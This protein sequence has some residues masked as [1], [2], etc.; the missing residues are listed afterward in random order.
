MKRSTNNSEVKKLNRN[1]VFRYIN[2]CEET[3]M[4]EISA[5][6]DI[7]SPTVLTIVKELKEDGLIT[8]VGEFKSTGGRKA[9]ALA[10]VKDNKYAVGL[11]ITRNHV[12][13]AYTDLSRKT[14]QYKRIPAAFENTVKYFEDLNRMIKE[15]VQENEIPE[16]K[17]TGVGIA[18]P[19]IID[20]DRNEINNSRALDVYHVPCERWK[21]YLPYHC[22]F[23]ND[24]NA[25][26]LTENIRYSDKKSMVYLS[27]SN[28][29]GGSIIFW[30][31]E[32]E[33]GGG[34][35]KMYLGD[36]WRSAE[37][38]H[39][40]IHPDGKECYCGKRG[41]LDAYCSALV[42]AELENGKLER[43]FEQMEA[44]NGAYRQVWEKY[45]DDLAIG[46]DNLRMCFDC[47]IVLGGYVGC[48]ME[49]YIE[50]LRQRVGEKN[51]FEGNGEY[52]RACR[53]KKA[54]T[55]LGAAISQIENYISAI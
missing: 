29:V 28:T 43:F 1:R 19:A 15:F 37:F 33:N 5:A 10:A 24:A 32:K 40:V 6:L 14:L 3:C 17:L 50:E 49:P 34:Y 31:P 38:G 2:D 55:V 20:L 21:S 35:G 47:E 27:L 4:P 48:Y 30:T 23:I 7:S 25:A 53:Y 54:A 51:I 52:V 45:L 18:V 8:E 12:G 11:D 42:L 41:C 46:V 39:V 26:A 13:I 9:K 44:G 36:E 16:E 22:E